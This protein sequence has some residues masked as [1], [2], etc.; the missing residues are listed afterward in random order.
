ML[1]NLVISIVGSTLTTDPLI[2][3][4]FSYIQSFNPQAQLGEA[5]NYVCRYNTYVILLFRIPLNAGLFSREVYL[6]AIKRR[7][8]AMDQHADASTICSMQ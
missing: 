3:S 6:E 8:A 1:Y 4:L 5:V 7:A 2:P